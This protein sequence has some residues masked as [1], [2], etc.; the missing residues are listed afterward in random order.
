M[1]GGNAALEQAGKLV[2]IEAAAERAER[3]RAGVPAAVGFAD[4]VT[5]GA[6]FLEQR[7]A[8]PGRLLGL[9]GGA[10]REEC[11]EERK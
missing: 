10:R 7:A 6:E 2:E 8:L 1:I 4:G 9:R 5:G 11:D 3:L